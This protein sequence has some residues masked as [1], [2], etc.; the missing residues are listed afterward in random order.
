[1]K[2]LPL[3]SP[4]VKE[5]SSLVKCTTKASLVVQ[6]ATG[7]ALLAA[8]FIPTSDTSSS[9]DEIYTI[10][11]LETASQL[12][13]LAYYFVAVICYQGRITTWTRYI[14]WYI[15]TPAMLVSTALFFTHRTNTFPG[16]DILSVL[17]FCL[18]PYVAITLSLNWLMLSFGLAIEVDAIPRTIGLAS[19]GL[20][21]TGSFSYLS[22]Y[23]DDSD[24]MSVILLFSMFGVWFLYGIAAALPYVPRNVSYNVL[25]IVSKNFY[26]VFLTV[27]L[28]VM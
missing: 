23:V 7:L 3:S 27:Y 19:G 4:E 18:N 26:G 28:L 21:L 15:S 25:D 17:T 9:V 12:V 8:F 13:E 22:R 20:A 1:M 16:T 14:D 6:F 10:I 2:T 5:D 24:V 11:V